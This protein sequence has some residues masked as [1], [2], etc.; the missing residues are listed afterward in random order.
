MLQLIENYCEVSCFFL[1]NAICKWP[2]E[3]EPSILL[4]PIKTT[5]FCRSTFL[6]IPLN[7]G[8]LDILIRIMLSKEI[9]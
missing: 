2:S 4:I 6:L 9:S 7:I 8:H 5:D 3:L 1:V